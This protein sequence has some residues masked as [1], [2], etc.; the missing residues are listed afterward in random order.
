[1]PLH[2]IIISVIFFV[3]ALAWPLVP[4]AAYGSMTIISSIGCFWSFMLM[5]LSFVYG[6]TTW[7]Y[8]WLAI[9]VVFVF[10]YPLFYFPRIYSSKDCNFG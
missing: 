4:G 5:G 6:L 2:V 1:M 10:G 3:L 8:I 7:G 9:A